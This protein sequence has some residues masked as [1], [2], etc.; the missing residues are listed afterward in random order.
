MGIIFAF[1]ALV[2]WGFGDFLIQRSARKFGDAIA[3]FC[4]TAF[5][6]IVLFPFV[7]RDI[8]SLLVAGDLG[9]IAL[10][11]LTTAVIFVASV[12]DFEALRIGK[13]SAIEPIYAFEIIITAS[14]SALIIKEQ[15][16]Y[17]QMFLVFLVVV[18]IMLVSLKSFSHLKTIT[19]ERG[20]VYAIIATLAM[21]SANFLFGVGSRESHP[22]LVNWFTS[23]GMA[24]VLLIYIIRTGKWQLLKN[25]LK[26][27]A[28]LL[29]G[30][31][32]IDNIAWVA[33]A[34]STLFIPIAIATSISE[35]YIVLAALLGL[36]V[37]KEKL[38]FH[39]YV[40]LTVTPFAA[41]LLSVTLK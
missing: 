40:G 29:F 17:L 10:L 20:V 12:F 32:I 4:V 5:A 39:Q 7:F 25:D 2:S 13:L 30:V 18:G 28:P 27:Y 34:Y 41:I 6:G 11:V 14:L 33:F 21:G 26:K 8:F 23:F 35:S 37:N 9:T 3:L 31:S 36:T 15:L 24:G 38:K 22:L 16:N 19:W 1:I